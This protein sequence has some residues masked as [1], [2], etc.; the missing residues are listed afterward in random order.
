MKANLKVVDDKESKSMS[1]QL[2]VNDINKFSIRNTDDLSR[3]AKMMSESG[4][5][6]DCKQA[7]QAGVKVL[8]GLELGI[9]A[10]AS[11]TGIHIIAGKP[12][13]GANLMAAMIK[14]SGKYNYKILEH[15]DKVCRLMFMEHGDEMGVSEYTLAEALKSGTKNLDKFA[16]NMLFARAISNGIK[17]FCPDLF[18][19]APVYTPEELG[20]SVDGEGVML[21]DVSH[22]YKNDNSSSNTIEI[23]ANINSEPVNLEQQTGISEAYKKEAIEAIRQASDCESLKKIF[24]KYYTAVKSSGDSEFLSKLIEVKDKAKIALDFENENPIQNLEPTTDLQL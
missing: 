6:T 20:A 24:M 16:K 18:L 7:A 23:E 4:F 9:P 14:N 3:L 21:K 11:M 8:A 17:W 15:T 22:V 12:A 5:F 13:I 19:G 2:A 10:F 1:N